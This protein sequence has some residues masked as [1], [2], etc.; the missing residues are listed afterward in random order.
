MIGHPVHKTL[1]AAYLFYYGSKNTSPSASD[2]QD[3]I[4]DALILAKKVFFRITWSYFD[5]S[6][7]E[8]EWIR[9]F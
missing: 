3:L 1:K 8:T 2:L 9:C 4:R 7:L 6:N 5:F